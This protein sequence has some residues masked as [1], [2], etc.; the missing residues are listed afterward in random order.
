MMTGQGY[1]DEASIERTRDVTVVEYDDSEQASIVLIETV[2]SLRGCDP[3][4]LEPLY[5]IADPEA[6][7]ALC[8]VETTAAPLHLSFEYGGYRIVAGSDGRI[9]L[10]A[11]DA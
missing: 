4:D 6:L 9:E 8:N 2:A 7:D 5:E 3:T 1:D 10:S 11:S